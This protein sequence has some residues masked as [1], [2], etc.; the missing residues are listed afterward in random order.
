MFR[1]LIHEPWQDWVPVLA[2]LLTFGVFIVAFVR[3]MLL[4]K[5]SV[6]HMATLPLDEVMPVYPSHGPEAAAAPAARPPRPSGSVE[7]GTDINATRDTDAG[8]G[9]DDDDD[10]DGS[11]AA[12][13]KT[14]SRCV[15]CRHQGEAAHVHL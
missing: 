5:E 1:R 9:A 13:S 14:C 15:A 3:A 4:K 7:G 12:C 2:F 8:K 10:D 11:G 6:A